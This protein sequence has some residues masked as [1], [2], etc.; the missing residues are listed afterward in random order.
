EASALLDELRQEMERPFDL[1]RGPLTRLLVLSRRPDQHYL[2]LS[3]HHIVGELWALVLIVQELSRLYQAEAAGMPLVITPLSHTYA[4]SVPDEQRRLAGAEGERLA[5]YW[6]GKLTPPPLPLTLPLS[7]PRPAVQ[8]YRGALRAF[9]LPRASGQALKDLARAEG[10]TPFAALV[11]IF[12][13]LLKRESGQTDIV[14]GSPMS[15]RSRP[16]WSG[17]VG[18]FDNP[19][20]LRADLSGRPSFRDVLRRMRTTAL[21]A[22]AHQGYPFPLMVERAPQ[23]RAP[24]RSPLVDVMFVL[25]QSPVADLQRLTRL[26]MGQAGAL[27]DLGDGLQAESVDLDRRVS[28]LD[29]TLAVTEEA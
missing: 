24:S 4:A 14:I 23:P 18:F 11:A 2:L 22:L 19:V 16:E 28:Q 5:A 17:I 12:A 26:A 21:E 7:K 6:T 10:A 8:T 15:G 27:L 20:P 13:V 1:E 3:M 29:L 9:R 25:R